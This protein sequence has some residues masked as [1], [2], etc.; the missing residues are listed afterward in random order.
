MI[1]QQNE[2]TWVWAQLTVLVK[3]SKL[4]REWQGVLRTRGRS[5]KDMVVLTNGRCSQSPV[6]ED[7]LTV[8]G[9]ELMRQPTKQSGIGKLAFK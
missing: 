6:Q 7:G 9:A 1:T 3:A 5:G 2:H 8:C 4:G